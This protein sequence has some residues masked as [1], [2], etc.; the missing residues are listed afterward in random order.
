MIILSLVNIQFKQQKNNFSLCLFFLVESWVYQHEHKKRNKH[1]TQI[2][3][4]ISSFLISFI[5]FLCFF[6]FFFF[7]RFRLVSI[8]FLFFCYFFATF[9][10]F[11]F[12]IESK[13]VTKNKIKVS[14]RM[15]K[16]INKI[17]S[18]ATLFF[19]FFFFILFI[20]TLIQLTINKYTN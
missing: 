3:F 1:K 7:V 15:N 8:L 19:F 12:W 6:S 2:V 11:F 9:F 5:I 18:K 13:K 20:Q 14:E 17:N 10:F 4:P 16:Q